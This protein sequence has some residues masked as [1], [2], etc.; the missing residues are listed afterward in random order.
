[1][2]ELF[3][4]GLSIIAIYAM[5]MVGYVSYQIVPIHIF[6]MLLPLIIFGFFAGYMI[7]WNDLI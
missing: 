5:I 4:K 7:G 3:F 2:S 6:M 1:M